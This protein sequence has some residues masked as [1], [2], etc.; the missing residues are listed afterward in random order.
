MRVTVPPRQAAPIELTKELAEAGRE[1]D[2]AEA[3]RVH[4]KA[5]VL[6]WA[7]EH[8]RILLHWACYGSDPSP[9]SAETLLELG[10]DPN[11][12]DEDN[13]TPLHWCAHFGTAEHRAIGRHLIDHGANPLLKDKRGKTPLDF[14]RSKGHTEMARLLEE[15]VASPPAA[16]QG[17][18]QARPPCP[19]C[20][21]TCALPAV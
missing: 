11:R 10:A 9:E 4:G 6:A 18:G 1:A 12:G 20:A 8:G 16:A 7:D 15:H 17:P 19:L 5:V 3:I 2:R 13:M 21:V 14:A